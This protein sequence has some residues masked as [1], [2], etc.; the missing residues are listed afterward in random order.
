MPRRGAQREVLSVSV[1]FVC[2]MM[3]NPRDEE[4]SRTANALVHGT[5]NTAKLPCCAHVQWPSFLLDRD[6]A[7]VPW[8]GDPGQNN[9]EVTLTKLHGCALQ[10]DPDHGHDGK[11]ALV[12][13]VQMSMSCG[14]SCIIH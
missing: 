10:P 7:A 6:C 2:Y 5:C 14:T 4:R 11:Y 8:Y 13:Q 9:I 3:S 12:V 1:L